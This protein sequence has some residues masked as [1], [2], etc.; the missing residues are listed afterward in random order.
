MDM[1]SSELCNRIDRHFE[2]K[3]WKKDLSQGDQLRGSCNQA[4]GNQ[5]LRGEEVLHE[6][7]CQERVWRL[8][9]GL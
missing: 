5:G 8:S 7:H 3:K 1:T 4:G 6:R 2:K 9:N